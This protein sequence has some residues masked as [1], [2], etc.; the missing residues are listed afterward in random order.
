MSQSPTGSGVGSCGNCDVF[1]PRTFLWWISIVAES[2][3]LARLIRV[4]LYRRYIWFTAYI[5]SDIVC[6]LTM[7]WLT[8]DPH[9][10][11]YAWVW[12]WTQPVLLTL[13]LALSIELYRLIADHY[14]NF[15][16][17]R[18]RLFWT[19]L[20]SATAVSALTLIVDLRHVVWKSP[21]LQS[22]F[23]AKRTVTFALSGFVI[24]TSIFLRLF[25]IPIRSN[26]TVHRRIAT[27]YFLANAANYCALDVGLLSTY[28]AGIALMIITGCC[29]V[30]WAVFLKPQ[31]EQ[32]ETPPAPT[33]GEIEK[34][35]RQGD[36]LLQRV[37][38]IRR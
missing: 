14:R 2:I 22:E 20:I 26:V 10:V 29:F 7:M 13:Q 4:N 9:S 25:P 5:V 30:A 11:V 31:G 8:P 35:L 18:A 34:H 21:I 12:V 32:V 16:R 6:S 19:C 28:T 38:E 36:K 23:L 37:R 3:L 15:E 33:D 24:A 27:V 1:T 17:Y